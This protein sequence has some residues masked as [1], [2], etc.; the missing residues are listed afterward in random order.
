LAVTILYWSLSS[1]NNHSK[2]AFKT[3]ERYKISKML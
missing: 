2:M 3:D 1:I